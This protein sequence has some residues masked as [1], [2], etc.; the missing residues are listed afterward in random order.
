MKR[1]YVIWCPPYCGS[2]GVRALYTLADRLID[3]GYNVYLY[4][5]GKKIDK[6][7]YVSK[8]SKRLKEKAVAVYPEV[9][10]GNPLGIKNIA[11]YVL[12]YPGKN[13][14]ASAYHLSE[15]IFTWDDKY[16]PGA[17]RL[18]FCGIDRNL[19]YDNKSPKLHNCYFVHKGGITR[20]ISE[21][22]SAIQINMGFPETRE[23]LADLLRH[24]D[25]L[26][27]Y[28]KDTVLAEEALLCGAKVKVITETS[29]EEYISQNNF[30]EKILQ[31]ELNEFMTKTQEMNYL[32]RTEGRYWPKFIEYKL[33]LCF[34]KTLKFVTRNKK[35][36]AQISTY[37]D[38]LHTV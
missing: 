36:K 29:V 5:W 19:F 33:K 15:Q 23:K 38:L 24:T 21:I 25:I 20:H 4:S 30:S 31:K 11:R 1:E 7:Q 2:N 8:I 37:R 35:Y 32:G 10:W 16:Y 27:T 26:Y 22:D 9:V 17:P 12:F 18:F 13:G 28:D 14:G 6:Y 3:A 34:Y